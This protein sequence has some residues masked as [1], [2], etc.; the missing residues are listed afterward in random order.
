MTVSLLAAKYKGAGVPAPKTPITG[1][2]GRC[3]R[4]VCGN[5]AAAPPTNERES[6]RRGAPVPTKL[7]DKRYHQQ[8]ERRPRGNADRHRHK[9]D[10]DDHPAEIEWETL[11]P[12]GVTI[13]GHAVTR[14]R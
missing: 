10:G 3:A 6:S 4:A 14:L 1:I 13:L 9:R 8:R 2:A 7:A 11:R 5:I 12:T